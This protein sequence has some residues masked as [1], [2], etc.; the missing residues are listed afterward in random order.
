MPDASRNAPAS[1]RLTDYQPSAFT[2][3]LVELEFDLEPDATK[4]RSRLSIRRQGTHDKSLVLVGEGVNGEP[5]DTR[6]VAVDGRELGEHEYHINADN[7]TID[8]V[9]DEFTLETHCVIDPES[10]LALSGLYRSSGNFCTQCEPEGFRRITWFLDRPDVLA[11]YRVTLIADAKNNPVMLANGNRVES[12]DLDNGKRRVSWHDPWPKPSY[13]FALVAGD[14]GCLRD[15]F[16]T[17]SGRKVAL[18]VYAQHHNMDQCDHAMASLKQAMRWDEEVY[19]REYDLDI[20][21]IVAV[22]DFNMGAMENKGLNIFNSRYV[23]ARPETATDDDFDAIEGVIGHEYFHN[24][25]GNR[26]TCRDWFQLSL[27][28][29][30]TV[31]RDQEFSAAMG[32]SGVKRISDVNILRAHQF[33]EDSGPM[34]HPVRPD[35]YVEINN[36]YTVTV[37]NK[38]AEVVRMLYNLLGPEQFRAGCDLYFDRHDGQAVTTD[39]FVRAHEDA[40][41]RQFDQFRRWY[42]QAGTPR[43]TASVEF[44]QD[45]QHYQLKLAQNC[46]P[47][48]AQPDKKS[49]H[50]P[51]RGA[52]FDFDG[53][54]V[55]CRV[56]DDSTMRQEHVFELTETEQSF[57]LVGIDQPVVPSLLRGF[58]APVKLDAGLDRR[59]L[60]ILM[61]HDTDPFNRWDAGQRL[62]LNEI[63]NGVDSIAKGRTPQFDRIFIDAFGTLLASE[64]DDGAFHAAALA[65]PQYAIVAEELDA[66]DPTAVNDSL[67]ALKATLATEFQ[68]LLNE[69]YQRFVPEIAYTFDRVD[70]GR[71][72]LKNCLLGYLAADDAGA[73]SN[74]AASQFQRADNMTDRMGALAT[75]TRYG[76]ECAEMLLQTFYDDW[77]NHSLVVDKWLRLQASSPVLGTVE[78]LR[79][80]MG[81]EAY[82]GKNPNKIRAL[83]GA[84]CQA[85]PQQFHAVDGSGYA[86]LTEQV[87]MLDAV[88]PQVAARLVSAFNQWK[89]YRDPWRGQM[90][91]SLRQIRERET[92]SRDVSEIVERALNED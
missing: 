15:E 88:N 50:I 90:R 79:R 23:L 65:L 89:R 57:D 21:M 46:P 61:A 25:S 30:F 78:N 31:F 7:L 72:A 48:P 44:N 35:S 52:F 47:T 8:N 74:L 58:S 60:A 28:E 32:S 1:I 71:R 4:V 68:T 37:Y 69:R 41:G 51:L 86:L 73:V 20:Y 67:D 22:D 38:G 36:F 82:N 56:G 76:L 6:K 64:L 18:E 75:A 2:I 26:V 27:K 39:D 62:A 85:N 12:V 29:G 54:P 11:E 84:F 45:T 70:N 81:H 24:W 40:S 53:N 43:V 83:V 66:I 5:L 63:L 42:E 14:L 87:L 13:L 17:R 16:V 59:A 9:G 3:D 55:M 33:P 92:L 80:L 19:G 10:N 77:R 49:F 91:D 34:A